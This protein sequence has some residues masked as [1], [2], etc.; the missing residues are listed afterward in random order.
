M[1]GGG[2][3][4]SSAP[5]WHQVVGISLAISSGAFIGT[6][7]ILKKMGIL[8]VKKKHG[9]DCPGHAYVKN[10]VWWSGLILSEYS[11]ADKRRS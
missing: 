3:S 10:P 2:S 11:L 7:Y 8:M 6:S 5:A 1:T 4:S 9:D